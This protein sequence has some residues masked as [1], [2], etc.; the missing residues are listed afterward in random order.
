[1]NQVHST[2]DE[3][4]IQLIHIDKIDEPRINKLISR[5]WFFYQFKTVKTQSEEDRFF[6]NLQKMTPFN[7]AHDSAA[8]DLVIADF[9]NNSPL[10]PDNKY[11]LISALKYI[12]LPLIS[13]TDDKDSTCY[14]ENNNWVHI[15]VP[16]TQIEKHISATHDAITNFWFSLPSLRKTKNNENSKATAP[17]L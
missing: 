11:A 12:R 8:S 10:Q 6:N 2:Q 14:H 16:Y 7:I 3:A 15:S 13:L 9:R 17:G 1:M 5:L 4:I